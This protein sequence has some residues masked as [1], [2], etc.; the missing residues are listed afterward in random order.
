MIVTPPSSQDFSTVLALLRI[1]SDPKQAKAALDALAASTDE[2]VKATADHH[3]AART[4]REQAERAAA[5]IQE[6]EPKQKH[7]EDYERRLLAREKEVAHRESVI[8][9]VKKSWTTALT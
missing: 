1:V 2:L 7:L 8:N 9:E 5:L 4:A 6:I 3:A